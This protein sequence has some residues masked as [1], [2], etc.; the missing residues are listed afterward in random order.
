MYITNIYIL[1]D[2]DM[3]QSPTLGPHAINH[4]ATRKSKQGLETP[5]VTNQRVKRDLTG[6][7]TFPTGVSPTVT[8]MAQN[9][10]GAFVSAPLN[11]PFWFFFLIFSLF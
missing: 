5:G 9:P 2:T 4:K 1:K 11:F 10:R 6:P 3:S 8:H 7:Q